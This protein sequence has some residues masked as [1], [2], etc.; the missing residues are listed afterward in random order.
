LP[1]TRWLHPGRP[2]RKRITLPT[3]ETLMKLEA[4]ALLPLLYMLAAE[5][6]QT[7][8]KQQDLATLQGTW[9]PV[10]MEMDGKFLTAE[11]IGKT[12]LTIKGE[13]FTFDT[14]KDSHEGLY[15]LDPSHDPKHL[16][17]LIT[18]GDEV[19]KTYLV[20]YKFSEG[21]MIQCMKVSNAERP[22]DFTGRKGSGNLYE[23]WERVK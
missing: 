9:K 12:R 4:L 13:K 23:I 18:R 20:I 22:L 15:K 6:A 10:S 7:E 5:P 14:G 19:G 11:Q 3:G 1:H 17:I 8:V 16:D 21:K 2:C